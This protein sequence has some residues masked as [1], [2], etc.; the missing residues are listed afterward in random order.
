MT[1]I[2][3]KLT[4]CILNIATVASLGTWD[5]GHLE[6]GARAWT[7][8]VRDVWVLAKTALAG[9]AADGITVIAATGAGGSAF[10]IRQSEGDMYWSYQ[11]T[12][13]V[14]P[15]AGLDTNTGASP[16]QAIKTVAEL[17]RRLVQVRQNT[18]FTVNV[19]GDVPNTDNF[20]DRRKVVGGATSGSAYGSVITF[21]GQRTVTAAITLAAGTQQTLPTR[22]AAT[23]QAEAVL[24]AGSWVAADVGKLIVDGGGNTAFILSEKAAGATARV[25]DWIASNDAYAAAPVEG[26]ANVV[27]LTKWR[28]PILVGGVAPQPTVAYAV[29]WRDFDFDDTGNNI[30]PFVNQ[31]AVCFFSRCR[32]SNANGGTAVRFFTAGSFGFCQLTGCLVQ[33]TS[34]ISLAAFTLG[35][36]NSPGLS[37]LWTFGNGFRNVLVTLSSTAN[38]LLGVC[39]QNGNIE[40]SGT[41]QFYSGPVHNLASTSTGQWVGV[42]NDF[43]TFAT[44]ILGAI[45]VNAGARIRVEGSVYGTQVGT[46]SAGGMS[47]LASLNGGVM[48]LPKN[49][50]AA[51]T[52]NNCFNLVPTG[53]GTAFYLDGL[54]STTGSITAANG[55]AVLPISIVCT[56]FAQYIGAVANGWAR[57][58]RNPAN[59]GGFYQGL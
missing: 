38:N 7:A 3:S 16:A 4:G 43:N 28:A 37:L 9:T 15:A 1:P 13:S 36:A 17:S 35:H 6:E 53:A 25:T 39:V 20:A 58:M 45:V 54:A 31:G 12:W 59:N 41:T 14:D 27:T 26:A 22:A 24:G 18:S 34:P 21:Q 47:G 48:F 51:V 5:A 40:C 29:A 33:N 30:R 32:I 10:W 44:A 49:M 57:N 46:A 19:L 8:D 55:G 23:A 42:Y 52:A 50:D 56:T 11:G 2:F